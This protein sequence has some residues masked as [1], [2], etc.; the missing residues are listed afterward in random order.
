MANGQR[1]PTARQLNSIL[2]RTSGYEFFY[3]QSVPLNAPQSIIV[4]RPINL[5]RPLES[6]EIRLQFRHGI[7]VQPKIAPL[8]ESPATWIDRIRVNGQH[9]VFGGQTPIDLRGATA[10]TWPRIFGVKGNDCYLSPAGSAPIRQ[11]DP[12]QPYQQTI[13]NY[14]AVGNFDVDLSVIIPVGVVM[15]M[16]A[17]IRSTL[18]FL[19]RQQD[20][21]DSLQLRIDLADSSAVGALNGGT[22][23]LTSYQSASGLPLLT[24]GLNYS[25]LGP[26]DNPRQ[27]GEANLVIRNEQPFTSFTAL[28]ASPT[29]VTN[30]QKRKTTNIIVKSGI[31]APETAGLGPNYLTLDDQLLEMTQVQIDTKPVRNNSKNVSQKSHLGR[32]F[33][34]IT[35]QGYFPISFVDSTSPLTAFA[36]DTVGGGAQFQLLSAV[37]KANAGNLISVV[38]EQ[39][40]STRPPGQ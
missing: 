24:V 10:Y 21:A 26:L 32:M 23:S 34:T 15:G 3:S 1:G 8:A 29:L 2:G 16:G 25:Q 27:P 20:W 6:I 39:I 19:W 22:D 33:E 14:G 4:P 30:L 35:P 9:R 17:R 18:P 37:M 11:A 38:Q 40:L 31:V 36:G 28:T 5:N 7:T 12:G 13:A